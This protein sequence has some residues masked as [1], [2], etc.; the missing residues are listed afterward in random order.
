[1]HMNECGQA[2]IKEVVARFYR[3]QQ[4]AVFCF[5]KA[6]SKE[7]EKYFEAALSLADYCSVNPGLP[8]LPPEE[9]ERFNIVKEN[10]Q[11]LLER[12]R[13]AVPVK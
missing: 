12:L 7:L 1:M 2:P 10:S 4:T 8:A 11:P 6:L 13:K 5:E 9:M 3:H